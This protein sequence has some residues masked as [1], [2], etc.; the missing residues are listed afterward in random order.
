MPGATRPTRSRPG[1]RSR[2]GPRT[3]APR[4]GGGLLDHPH[5]AL[6]GDDHLT[7]VAERPRGDQ[8]GARRAGGSGGHVSVALAQ[9]L[10]PARDRGR[11]TRRRRDHLGGW[12]HGRGELRARGRDRELLVVARPAQQEPEHHTDHE[13]HRRTREQRRPRR[14]VHT[15]TLHRGPPAPRPFA[16]RCA[17]TMPTSRDHPRRPPCRSVPQ[18]RDVGSRG[19]RPG[20]LGADP[21]RTR[22]R[23]G[24]HDRRRAASRSPR[25]PTSSTGCWPAAG[26]RTSV[27]GNFLDTTADK[28]LV[29]GALIGLLVVGRVSPWIAVIIIGRE[30]LIIGLKGAVASTGDLVQPV[31]LGQGEGQRAVPRDLPR[32][33]APRRG[34]SDRC[35]WISGR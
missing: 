34:R 22:Q 16:A 33:P 35:T 7:A 30:I 9:H 13:Q 25:S 29:A 3:R 14:S 6:V 21:R 10:P 24:L 12:R 28:L 27:F 18:G 31:R 17:A 15:P 1:R 4:R 11:L 5:H 32:D 19:A 20:D 2:S 23:H 26:R 8:R